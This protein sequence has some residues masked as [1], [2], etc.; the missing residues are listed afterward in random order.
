MAA[1]SRTDQ[2]E[3]L[4]A[5]LPGA[6]PRAR[7]RPSAAAL[8]AE[9]QALAEA[10]ALLAAEEQLLA[11]ADARLAAEAMAAAQRTAADGDPRHPDPSDTA[12][13]L[14]ERLV[15]APKRAAEEARAT[16]EATAVTLTGQVKHLII[17]HP[18]AALAVAF[19]IGLVLGRGR[20][21]N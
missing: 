14:V 20:E 3:D 16:V 7:R 6:R 13:S 5:E 2:L 11:D 17:A 15:A 21:R 19:S 18:M 4:K 8:A 1:R 10:E 12:E 9:A